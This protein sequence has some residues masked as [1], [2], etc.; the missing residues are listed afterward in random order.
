MNKNTYYCNIHQVEYIIITHSYYINIDTH[1]NIIIYWEW[2]VEKR[3]KRLHSCKNVF[4][5]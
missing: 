3:V 1:K 4:F 2:I 5:I